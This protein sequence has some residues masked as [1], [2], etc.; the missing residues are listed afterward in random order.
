MGGGPAGAFGGAFGGGAGMSA[1]DILGQMFGQAF[2]VGGGGGSPFGG[3]GMGGMGRQPRMR[4]QQM[5]MYATLEELYAG[6]TKR[7][8]IR[9]PVL[10]G[11]QLR[12]ERVEAD[13]PLSPGARDGERFKINGGSPNRANVI[14]SVRARPHARFERRGDDLVCGF[15]VSLYEALTGFRAFKHLDGRT[16]GV[17]CDDTVTRPGMPCAASACR[18]G[19]SAARATCWCGSRCAS[20]RAALGRGEPQ[21][22]QA[23]PPRSAAAASHAAPPAGQRLYR[24]EPVAEADAPPYDA[25]DDTGGGWGV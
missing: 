7:V 15:E 21:G 12:E 18:V 11:R 10:H 17:A 3:G 25:D 13:I 23:D 6:V 8:A 5:T 24:L 9:R 16:I 1:E 2:G 20:A 19:R 4:D 14:I 22:A